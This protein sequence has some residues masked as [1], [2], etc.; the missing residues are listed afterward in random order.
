MAGQHESS[1]ELSRSS[2]LLHLECGCC[3]PPK[4]EFN[5]GFLRER[6]T[7]MRRSCRSLHALCTSRNLNVPELWIFLKHECWL[8]KIVLKYRCQLCSHLLG[9]SEHTCVSESAIL[10]TPACWKASAITISLLHFYKPSLK[11]YWEKKWFN[12]VNKLLAECYDVKSQ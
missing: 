5:S 8:K 12:Y 9:T 3:K 7:L 10:K 6:L 4:R 1:G 2:A 11:A